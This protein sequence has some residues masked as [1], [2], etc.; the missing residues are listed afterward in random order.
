MTFVCTVGLFGVWYIAVK[1]KKKYVTKRAYA[2]EAFIHDL[3][4]KSFTYI[5]YFLKGAC[6]LWFHFYTLTVILLHIVLR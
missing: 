5:S 6:I 4:M 3:C 2:F 1:S